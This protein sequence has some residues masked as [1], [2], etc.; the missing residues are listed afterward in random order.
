MGSGMMNSATAAG[1]VRPRPNSRLRFCRLWTPSRSSAFSAR[2]SSGKST[3]P[4]AMPITPSGSWLIRSAK[5][6]L[7]MAPLSPDTMI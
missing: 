6:M 7:A 1:T 2:D 3:T 5:L 4:M